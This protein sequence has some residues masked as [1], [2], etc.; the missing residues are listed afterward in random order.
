M[1]NQLVDLR[2]QS[3]SLI[4]RFFNGNASRASLEGSGQSREPHHLERIASCACSGY[5]HSG[6]T[7]DAF[8]FN[9]ELPLRN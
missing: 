7:L 3:E 6:Y 4:R 5:F 9:A 1:R 2:N 8:V